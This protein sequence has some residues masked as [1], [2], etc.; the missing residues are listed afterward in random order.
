M[1]FLTTAHASLHRITASK[2]KVVAFAWQHWS[3]VKW[4]FE[5][6]VMLVFAY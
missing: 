6:Y 3:I 5:A 1:L 4:Q 2:Q